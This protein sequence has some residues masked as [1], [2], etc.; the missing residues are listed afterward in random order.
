MLTSEPVPEEKKNESPKKAEEVPVARFDKPVPGST[1]RC[2]E[3]PIFTDSIPA[4]VV[5]APKVPAT[6]GSIEIEGRDRFDRFWGGGKETVAATTTVSNGEEQKT[7]NWKTGSVA[8]NDDD[9]RVS[10]KDF[11]F[12]YWTNI[13]FGSLGTH[14]VE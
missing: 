6:S 2:L 7:V 11:R 1:L 5:T 14:R 13:M 10:S 3:D 8:G 4:A 9:I 12:E